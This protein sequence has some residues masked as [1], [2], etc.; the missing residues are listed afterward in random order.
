M[1]S[2]RILTTLFCQNLLHTREEPLYTHLTLHI[3]LKTIAGY[4]RTSLDDHH[5]TMSFCIA[6]NAVSASH[7]RNSTTSASQARGCSRSDSGGISSAHPPPSPYRSQYPGVS[8]SACSLRWMSSPA[9]PCIPVVD[10]RWPPLLRT[11]ICIA[12]LT[13]PK[14]NTSCKLYALY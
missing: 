6:R 1:L 10:K 12:T 2:P 14:R 7:W 5:S 3:P 13:K 8:C 9:I 4:H 11:W